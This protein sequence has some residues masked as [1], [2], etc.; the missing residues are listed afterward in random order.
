MFQNPLYLLLCFAKTFIYMLLRFLE[1]NDPQ[2]FPADLRPTIAAMVRGEAHDGVVPTC[3]QIFPR[4]RSTSNDSSEACTSKKTKPKR[5]FQAASLQVSEPVTLERGVWFYE[6]IPGV[7]HLGIVGFPCCSTAQANFFK[8]LLE[9]LSQLPSNS[10]DSQQAHNISAL[11]AKNTVVPLPWESATHT[12]NGTFF[13]KKS[14]RLSRSQR[15][16]SHDTRRN[17][18]EALRRKGKRPSN[19]GSAEAQTKLPAS[20]CPAAVVG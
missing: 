7:D 10:T 13:G 2:Q 18:L 14:R 8:K 3:S 16:K 20:G 15:D 12:N 4:L 19:M 11:A 9:R 1:P 17:S 6:T 5:Q